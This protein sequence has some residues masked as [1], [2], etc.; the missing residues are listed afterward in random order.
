MATLADSGLDGA[1]ILGAG[2][3]DDT[4]YAE[5][6]G[7]YALRSGVTGIGVENDTAYAEKTGYSALRSTFLGFGVEGLGAIPS[8]PGSFVADPH[9]TDGDKALL[10]WTEPAPGEGALAS[11]EVRRRL[12]AFLSEADWVSAFVVTDP[13]PTISDI[14]GTPKNM[15]ATGLVQDTDYFFAVRYTNSGGFQGPFASDGVHTRDVAVPGT[16]APF[17]AAAISATQID[18]T[19]NAPDENGVTPPLGGTCASYLLKRKTGADFLGTEI[20][21]NNALTIASPVPLA[22]PTATTISDTTVV[23]STTYYY[24][25]KSQDEAGNLSAQSASAFTTTPSGDVAAPSATE[26]TA[27]TAAPVPLT[28][29]QIDLQ[30]GEGADDA[31]NLGSGPVTKR[32]IARKTSAFTGTQPDFDAAFTVLDETTF[33][34]AAPGTTR[35]FADTAGIVQDTDY[36]YA[37]QT[38]DDVL[39]KSAI[40]LSAPSPVHSTDVVSPGGVTNVLAVG[41]STTTA[42]LQWDETGDSQGFAPPDPGSGPADHRIIRWSTAPFD[43]TQVQFDAAALVADPQPPM[44]QATTSVGMTVTGLPPGSSIFFALQVYDEAGNRGPISTHAAP[45]MTFPIGGIP[46]STGTAPLNLWGIG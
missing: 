45:A 15:T 37:I 17:N 34:I 24:R 13:Y 19:F 2:L 10:S 46:E 7:Y 11:L 40:V 18:L 29:T 41:T 27:F 3:E 32:R 8:A 42:L 16:I 44:A 38:E 20:D 26:T 9:A 25:I 1:H 30:W 28:G 12:T 4:A 5:K 21:F 14:V 6:T 33:A 43:T 23:G 36:F 39:Q 22:P 35:N 31:G